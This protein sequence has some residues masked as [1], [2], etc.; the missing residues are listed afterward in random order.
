MLRAAKSHQKKTHDNIF[1]HTMF[2][3]LIEAN[4]IGASVFLSYSLD[5]DLETG[6]RR[7]FFVRFTALLVYQ[8]LRDN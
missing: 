4:C 1:F 6:E 2:K 7:P 3:V 5:N 8:T